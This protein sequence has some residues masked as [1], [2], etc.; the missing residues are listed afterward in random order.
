M[1]LPLSRRN[2]LRGLGIASVIGLAGCT[3]LAPKQRLMITVSNSTK[4]RYI[5]ELTVVD[6]DTTLVRQYLELPAGVPNHSPEV[7]TVV[8]LGKVSKGKR[9]NVR[10]VVDG[11][12]GQHR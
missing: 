1:A 3:A 7:E 10:A 8:S 9:V 6:G 4:A 5:L 11:G 12:R 2:F